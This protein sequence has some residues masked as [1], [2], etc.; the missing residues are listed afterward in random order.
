MSQKEQGDRGLI[1]WIQRKQRWWDA[2]DKAIG[3]NPDGN[4]RISKALKKA[5][6]TVKEEHFH[7]PSQSGTM[8]EMA[9]VLGISKAD[10]V[11][12]WPVFLTG[13]SS[14][15]YHGMYHC[16]SLTWRHSRAFHVQHT[17]VHERGRE[18]DQHYTVR[19]L[20]STREKKNFWVQF[21]DLFHAVR[22][23]S[24]HLVSCGLC[25]FIGDGE[26]W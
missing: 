3:K 23:P 1:S 18:R 12:A 5:D 11:R 4:L 9:G 22:S 13:S 26:A 14:R 24:R 7:L 25:F 2:L 21:L 20:K 10:I 15:I 19:L 17:L 8:G 6:E 16:W